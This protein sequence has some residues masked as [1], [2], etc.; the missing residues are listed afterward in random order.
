M[1]WP[2]FNCFQPRGFGWKR[3]S[4]FKVQGLRFKV[5]DPAA[6]RPPEKKK[7]PARIVSWRAAGYQKNPRKTLTLGC[8][9]EERRHKGA[10]GHFTPIGPSQ[11]HQRL[12]EQRLRHAP[13]APQVLD[14]MRLAAAQL[15]KG[16]LSDAKLA[17]K[18][19]QS[20]RRPD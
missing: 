10:V 20:Q 17:G 11:P 2:P 8:T 3:L 1:K 16:P 14:Q 4:E 18:S 19:A 13:R 15:S 12:K 7:R 5:W 9:V 6:L